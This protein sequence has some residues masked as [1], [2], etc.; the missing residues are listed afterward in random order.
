M[1]FCF[2]DSFFS[3]LTVKMEVSPNSVT[4]QARRDSFWLLWVLE[5]LRSS[6]V[7]W[8]PCD[9]FVQLFVCLFMPELK[10]LECLG[11]HLINCHRYGGYAVMFAQQNCKSNVFLPWIAVL[12]FFQMRLLVWLIYTT[13]TAAWINCGLIWQ[14]QN[15]GRQRLLMLLDCWNLKMLRGYE[16]ARSYSL[17]QQIQKELPILGAYYVVNYFILLFLLSH[18]YMC[19]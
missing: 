2:L 3:I 17:C 16:G 4:K 7:D 6:A 10:P 5:L 15:D 9:G 18:V 8:K 19:L 12:L 14:K 11:C 1:H 13:L